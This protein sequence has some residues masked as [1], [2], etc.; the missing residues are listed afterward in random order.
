MARP[1]GDLTEAAVYYLGYATE[2]NMQWIEEFDVDV[3][4]RGFLLFLNSGD[5][6]NAEYEPRIRRC[7]DDKRLFLVAMQA[8]V[9]V[10][11]ASQLPTLAG[12]DPA[13]S[14]PMDSIPQW[15]EYACRTPEGRTLRDAKQ[16]PF[17]HSCINNAEFLR[18]FQGVFERFLR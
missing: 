9:L 11:N 15:Q 10:E 6:W 5:A 17:A 4:V 1:K 18:F 2:E 7:Q 16:M 13:L 3:L 8:A 14:F 12:D